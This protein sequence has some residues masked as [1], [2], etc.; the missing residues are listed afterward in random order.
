M[1][2]HDLDH[3]SLLALVLP[4]LNRFNWKNVLLRIL[5]VILTIMATEGNEAIKMHYQGPPITTC[6]SSAILDFPLVGRWLDKN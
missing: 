5:A 4:F 2:S 1:K 6:Y 3:P